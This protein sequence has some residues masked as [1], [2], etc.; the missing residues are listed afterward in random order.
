M[1]RVY[2]AA[3]VQ[4]VDQI[5]KIFSKV[6]FTSLEVTLPELIKQEQSMASIKHVY[7]QNNQPHNY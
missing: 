7:M 6:P 3:A 1:Y 4:R 5:L 2:R